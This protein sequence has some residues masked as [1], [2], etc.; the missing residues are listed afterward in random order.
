MHDTTKDTAPTAGRGAVRRRPYRG[1]AVGGQ[2]AAM[3]QSAVGADVGETF[4]IALHLTAQV[5]FYDQPGFVNLFT[6]KL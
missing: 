1:G 3:P 4:D 5:A 6:Q 2:I